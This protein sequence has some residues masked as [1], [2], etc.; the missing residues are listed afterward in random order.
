V[1]AGLSER[2]RL[3]GGPGIPMFSVEDNL[4]RGLA[5]MCA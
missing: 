2:S 5:V 4:A 3:Q 1:N